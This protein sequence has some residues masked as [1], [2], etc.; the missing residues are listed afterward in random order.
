MKQEDK[1]TKQNFCKGMFYYTGF[2]RATASLAFK[3]HD[4]SFEFES[5]GFQTATKFEKFVVG[6]LG[7]YHKVGKEKRQ[8]F[9][10]TKKGE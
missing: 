9:E 4:D 3:N 2:N 8:G 1:K 6:I 5:I 10:N 7:D